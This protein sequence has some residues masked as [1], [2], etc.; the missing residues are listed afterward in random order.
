MYPFGILVVISHSPGP[1]GFGRH[2]STVPWRHRRILCE[3]SVTYLDRH[4]WTWCFVH[5]NIDSSRESV[6][7]ASGYIYPVA[8]KV[9]IGMD[10][11]RLE[12]SPSPD[13]QSRLLLPFASV[14]SVP[15][16][17]GRHWQ[18]KPFS[19]SVHVPLLAHGYE[20][21]SSNSNSIQT[22]FFSWLDRWKCALTLITGWTG[23]AWVTLA[24]ERVRC[25]WNA[26][27]MFITDIRGAC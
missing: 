10:L 24:R 21:H 22:S 18:R 25:I 17:P 3:K 7:A 23:K 8:H 26:S 6:L 27:A 5:Q 20:R 19:K 9:M 15:F 14:Q 13:D 2:G 12:D 4:I 11:R 16:H 1:H